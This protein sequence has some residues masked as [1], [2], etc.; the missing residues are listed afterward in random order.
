MKE[1]IKKYIKNDNKYIFMGLLIITFIMM[2]LLNNFTPLLNDDYKYSFFNNIRITNIS[3]IIK[4]QYE[5]YFSWGGRSIVHIIAQFFLMFDKMIFNIA[6]S[7]VF[8]SYI[9]LIYYHV[10][11][12]K[13]INN[14]LLLTI[15]IMT[16]MFI[17]AFGETCLWLTGSCNYLWGMAIVLLFMLPYRLSL[18]KELKF[19]I[20]RIILLSLL[21]IL[22]GWCNEN[23]SAAMLFMIT[24]IIINKIKEKK[25]KLW[26]IIPYIFS[27]LGF[28]LMICAPGNYIRSEHF[29]QSTNIIVKYGRRFLSYTI[30]A[31]KKILPLIIILSIL[32]L[33]NY[34]NRN[35]KDCKRLIKFNLL[36]LSSSV[37]GIYSMIASPIFPDRAWFG[38]ITFLIIAISV[39]IIEIRNIEYKKIG[40][41]CITI[42]AIH[43]SLDYLLTFFDMRKLNME[44]NNRIELIRKANENNEKSVTFK[45]FE[46]YNK[47]NPII[48][49]DD[50][51]STIGM[52][53]YYGNSKIKRLYEK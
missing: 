33:L 21:G 6:N 47:K 49:L 53:E 28:V 18:D 46:T 43:C 26:H 15:I 5:H 41:C 34:L 4:C 29:T 2:F 22:A 39:N 38:V 42:L 16:W 11:G 30:N 24:L 40:V 52:I 27:I 9:L 12:N 50:A 1:K 48:G 36:Y 17:P 14:F 20:I 19:G 45:K 3:E 51:S 25:L 31:D 37:I 10:I 13:K 7:F 23:T 8:I 32:F 44:W 35:K